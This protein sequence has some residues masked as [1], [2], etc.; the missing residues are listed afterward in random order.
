MTVTATPTAPDALELERPE[1]IS[2]GRWEAI[3]AQ[4]HKIVTGHAPWCEDHRG[5]EAGEAGWCTHTVRPFCG[6]VELSTG[7]VTG[8]V[9]VA[10]YLDGGVEADNLTV[11]Q[12]GAIGSSLEQAAAIAAHAN[13]NGEPK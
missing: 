5:R 9:T 1:G 8:G 10:L 6:E 13:I 3:R 4:V 12:A 2:D 7:S 11:A